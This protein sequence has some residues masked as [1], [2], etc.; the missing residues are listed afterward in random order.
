M[1]LEVPVLSVQERY[2]L[3]VG[4]VFPRPIALISTRTSPTACMSRAGNLPTM[5]A[6]S[7]MRVSENDY[8]PVGRLYG[9]RYCTTRQRFELPGTL[10]ED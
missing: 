6:N 7:T 1:E 9:N 8:R 2:K 3:I 4:L 5:S 10:P